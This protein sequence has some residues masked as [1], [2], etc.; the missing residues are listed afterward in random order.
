VTARSRRIGP[1]FERAVADYL[2]DG[3]LPHADRR[4]KTGAK[5]KGDIGGV[6]GWTLECKNEKSISLAGYV[7]EAQVEAGNAGTDRYAAVV[8]RRGKG[9]RHAYVVMPLEVFLAIVTGEQ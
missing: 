3:G 9:V 1:E 8:K 2:R 5:D 7:D 6:P 4:V